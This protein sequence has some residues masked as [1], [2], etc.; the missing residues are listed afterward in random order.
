V[1]ELAREAWQFSFGEL[2]R[3]ASPPIDRLLI[4]R[5]SPSIAS[6][7]E[8]EEELKNSVPAFVTGTNR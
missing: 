1:A 7:L 5:K 6:M 3:S 8:A 2:T 4:A